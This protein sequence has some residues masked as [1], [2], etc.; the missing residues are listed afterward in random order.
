M[1]VF[2]YRAQAPGSGQVI[3][4]TIEVPSAAAGIDALRERGLVVASITQ[5]RAKRRTT[6]RK[7]RRKSISTDDL[8]VFS[9]Q[10]ATIVNAGLPLIEGLNILGDQ[11]ENPSFQ[12][13]IRT[14]QKDVESGSTLSDAMGKHSNTFSVLY[15]NLIRAGEVSGMLDSI[16]VQL[17]V[18]LEKAASLKR[19]VKGAM[20]YPAIVI[21][22]AIG[23]VFFLMVKVIP[24]FAQIFDS[25]QAELPTPTKIVIALSNFMQEFWLWGF[26]GLAV[27]GYLFKRYI[28]TRAGR[29]KF[30][31]LLL[32][33]PVIGPLFRKVAIARFTR[34]FETLLRS[35]VNI[36][37][38]LDIVAKTAGNMVVDEPE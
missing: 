6:A 31:T 30:D 35:G 13:I 10:L 7:G 22:V 16:L 12:T 36:L 9:R 25:F 5:T 18:Y 27:G 3:S 19:K 1:P 17:S 34:T 8:T 11:V 21:C 29:L 15:I 14:I 20:T 26:G 37:V 28:G 33:T 23:I 32:K 24:V 2:E 38:A 4:G